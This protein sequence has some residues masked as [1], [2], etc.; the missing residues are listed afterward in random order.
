VQTPQAEFNP[1]GQPS[2]AYR[3]GAWSSFK[4][5]M[6]ARFS[7]SDYPALGALKTRD[8]DDFTVAILDAAAIVLDILTFYQERL[9]NES[10]FRTAGQL[11]SLTELS[12]LIG[13]QP[14]PGVSASTYLAFTMKTAPGLPPDPTAP[15]ITIPM[16]TQVQSVP[17]QGQKPQTFETSV[18]IQAKP[19]WTAL[20]VQTGLAWAPKSQDT[21][22]YLA[23]VSTQ[24]QPG[25]AILVV[26]DERAGDATS[27]AWD[28]R[29][30][31]S[32]LVDG[33]NGRT[34]VTWS[35]GLGSGGVDPSSANPKFYAFRQ[36]AALFGYNAMDP[37][38]LSSK[39]QEGLPSGALTGSPKDWAFRVPAIISSQWI[40]LDSA[41]TKITPQGWIALIMPDQQTA[42]SPSGYVSLYQAQ[43]VTTIPR[44]GFGLSAKISRVRADTP[45]GLGEY[46]YA[47]RDTSALVQSELL[48]A[49][50]QPLGY[51]LYGSQIS[52]ESLRT[53]MTAIQAVAVFG[54]RQ[55]IAVVD[56]STLKA[57]TKQYNLPSPLRFDP[58]KPGK[59]RTLLPGE[60][61]TLTD[62]T[63]L[64][65]D[66]KSIAPDW[67]A[68]KAAAKRTF[69]VEDANGNLGVIKNALI[70]FTLVASGSSDPEVSEY[71]LVS[72]VDSVTDPAH[73][74]F[75][76]RNPLT[77]CY[78]RAS[79][80]VNANV[81]PAT[82]GQS[83]S[84]I[85]GSGSA[86]QPDQTFTLKQSPVT[87]VQ[88]P[89]PNGRKSTLQVL[90]NAVAWAEVP[91]LYG[92]GPSQQVYATLGQSDSTTDVLFGD[93]AEGSTLP[94]GQNNI[95]ANYRV[96]S[97]SAGNV[98]TGALSTLMDRPLGVS[99]VTN[100]E[101]TSGGQDPQTV[102]DIRANAP[103]TVLTLGR[104][105][106]ITDY[107]NYALA[108]SGIAKAYAL[109]IPSGPARGVFLTVAGAGGA[110]LQPPNTTITG[111]VTS[112]R[113]Y[114]NPLI[115]ITVKSFLETLFGLSADVQYGPS[116]DQPTA[117]ALVLQTLQQAFG[118]A[119]RDFGQGIS[120]DQVAAVI[121]GVPGVVAVN[122]KG[123]TLG[124][125]SAGGDL[126]SQIENFG[127]SALNSWL[128]AQPS[129]AVP[130]PSSGIANLYCPYLPVA[131]PKSQVPPL[132][133]EILVLNP[134]PSYV[135]L[136]I[137]S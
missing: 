91:S 127:S 1:P 14:A 63:A 100:P 13:Y 5:S 60:V 53:D 10:Y 99:G 59:A 64:P 61:L 124:M 87:Y 56:S 15:A 113:N 68:S 70:L 78:E 41:Y 80:T 136:G 58:G 72:S 110:D 112:L 95:Q 71:A 55:K 131:N 4:E 137:M 130:R 46:Y 12:R 31:S 107:Q 9:A 97:G 81:A 75:S 20:Q 86:S 6:L 89:T 120:A 54:K 65:L 126:A 116:V 102:G 94:T 7:S 44:S 26:G 42:R 19:D 109:W 38:L 115:P 49:A 2:V 114:G 22:V 17:A 48:A 84:E 39:I 125:T 27:K 104:A 47:T 57:L 66:S 23:G 33:P 106:S 105:V 28:V 73:T 32:V 98:G 82:H 40:D 108:Y 93:G 51:P 3:V 29:T 90:A 16:G 36:K 30:V 35:D 132:P 52:L 11:R 85:M 50:E 25:D 121:Q 103:L 135:N 129:V 122:V 128:A 24:V 119:N 74:V 123:I 62:P 43:A 111:L 83:V 18:D 45:T 92:Q 34:L 96:G 77:Y 8:D 76:L 134:D 69:T 79:T 37:S 133:A 117:Q 101:P 118:F 67:S 88:A 21:S